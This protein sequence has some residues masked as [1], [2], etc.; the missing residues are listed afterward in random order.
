MLRAAFAQRLEERALLSPRR[1][2]R[3]GREAHSNLP[4]RGIEPRNVQSAVVDRGVRSRTMMRVRANGTDTSNSDV[5]DHHGSRSFE[6]PRR[7]RRVSRGQALCGAGRSEDAPTRWHAPCCAELAA[8]AWPAGSDDARKVD[9]ARHTEVLRVNTVPYMLNACL[10]AGTYT[11]TDAQLEEAELRLGTRYPPS[12]RELVRV[13]GLFTLHPPHEPSATT[14]RVWPLAEHRT[15]LARAADEIGCAETVEAV[16]GALWLPEEVAAV[17]EQVVVVGCEHDED[18]VGFDLRTRDPR[19]LEAVFVLQSMHEK[20][21][22]HLASHPGRGS[23]ARG[24]GIWIEE[25][26]ARHPGFAEHPRSS[27]R[28]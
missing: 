16:A 17:L 11:P 22:E 3:R 19:T 5:F 9:S 21:L 7:A 26:P 12:F 2:E 27:C 14:F 24:F 6:R 1:C 8:A 25:F 18:F 13:H 15:A 10:R 20:K 23:A 28:W 4:S